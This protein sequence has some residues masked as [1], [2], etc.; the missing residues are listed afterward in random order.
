M[1]RGDCLN[2]G[3]FPPIW[4]GVD[5]QPEAIRFSGALFLPLD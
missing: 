4:L 3:I 5:T 2:W 1:R